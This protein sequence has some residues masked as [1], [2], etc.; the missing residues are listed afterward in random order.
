MK[1]IRNIRLIC[2]CLAVTMVLTF[3][4]D[5]Y[6][7]NPCRQSNSTADLCTQ[8]IEIPIV[9]GDQDSA[10]DSDGYLTIASDGD[11]GTVWISMSRAS[12]S[13]TSCT[14]YMRYVGT[15]TY[16]ASS[17]KYDGLTIKNSDV[18]DGTV[19]YSYNQYTVY[20]PFDAISS[21]YTVSAGTYIIP[22]DVSSV[23]VQTVKLQAYINSLASWLSMVGNSTFATIK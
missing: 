6:D 23:T 5:A 15:A 19:Y 17:L 11:F 20:L 7:S 4:V 10:F 14:L 21:L 3:T 13:S 12:S 2:L 1:T 16:A 9:I 18:L 22:T 8:S